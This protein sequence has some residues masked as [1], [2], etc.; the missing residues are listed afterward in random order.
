MD[1]RKSIRPTC[2]NCNRSRI[3]GVAEPPGSVAP[4]IIGQA[5]YRV[6]FAARNRA[7]REA[8]AAW[9]L[10]FFKW[11]RVAARLSPKRTSSISRR[12]IARRGYEIR[13]GNF[14]VHDG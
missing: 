1:C 13:K 7:S 14:G 5:I 4:V 11:L 12:M 8:S 10:H 3:D 9:H 2:L 6:I